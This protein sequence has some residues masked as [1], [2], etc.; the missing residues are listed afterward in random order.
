MKDGPLKPSQRDADCLAQFRQA[1]EQDSPAGGLERVR[2]VMQAELARVRRPRRSVWAWRT[3]A[4]LIV[5]CSG[6][7]FFLQSTAKPL[8]KPI[9]CPHNGKNPELNWRRVPAS[10]R[11]DFA[12]APDRFQRICHCTP[13]HSGSLRIR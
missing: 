4:M 8:A 2:W 13:Q 9:A 10:V 7:G 3:A 1:L 6:T 11:R 5:L 12:A